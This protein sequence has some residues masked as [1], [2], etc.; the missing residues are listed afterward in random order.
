MTDMSRSRRLWLGETSHIDR[1]M[2]SRHLRDAASAVYYIAGPPG[3]V[4]GLQSM[5][6]SVGINQA[7]IR[8]DEFSGY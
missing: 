6:A 8:T 2:L 1:A 7:D 3:M 5:L 4:G